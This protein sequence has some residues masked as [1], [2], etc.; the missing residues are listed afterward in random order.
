VAVGVHG[1]AFAQDVTDTEAS[2]VTAS[3]SESTDAL[4]PE[5][6]AAPTAAE[7]AAHAPL[8]EEPARAPSAMTS[9]DKDDDNMAGWAVI[10]IGGS[11]AATNIA[12][13][14]SLL[15]QGENNA[16]LRLGSATLI[17]GVTGF[18]TSLLVG[19]LMM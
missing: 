6:S 7:T 9:A 10:G 4:E 2:S 19:L 15:V 18:A 11:M 17:A 8:A 13:G 5:D 14:A 16:E 3:E 12:L 1:Q